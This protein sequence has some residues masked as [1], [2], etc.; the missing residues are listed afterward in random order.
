MNV[1]TGDM[2]DFNNVLKRNNK[3]IDDFTLECVNS[4][5]DDKQ[6][7]EFIES[8]FSVTCKTNNEKK[9]YDAGPGNLWLQDFENDLQQGYFNS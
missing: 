7:T 5:K 4:Y 6:K 3:N 2:N 8:E 9:R 1:S